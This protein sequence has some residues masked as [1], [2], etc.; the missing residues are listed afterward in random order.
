MHAYLR[1]IGLKEIINKKELK[2]L[3][4]EVIENPDE[5][6]IV[7]VDNAGGNV[8]ELKKNFADNMGILI[9]PKCCRSPCPKFIN[10]FL[11]KWE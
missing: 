10:S 8:A 3:L 9:H 1:S 2:N 7:S 6:K 4:L 5:Q 11:L